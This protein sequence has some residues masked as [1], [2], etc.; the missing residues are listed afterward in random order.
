MMNQL[1]LLVG[2]LVSLSL[3]IPYPQQLA[4]VNSLQVGREEDPNL[5]SCVGCDDSNKPILSFVI[6]EKS[7]EIKSI[8][9]VY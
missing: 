9:S 6:E 8:L 2:L 5:W 1:F 4:L 7:V 3:S